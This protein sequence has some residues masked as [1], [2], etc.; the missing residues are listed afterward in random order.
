LTGVCFI[1]DKKKVVITVIGKDTVGIVAKIAVLCAENNVN[2]IDVTQS[3]LGE[4]TFAMIMLVD[5]TSISV[6]FSDFNGKLDVIA[7][8]NNL[9]IH[10]VHE[11]VFNT[12]HHI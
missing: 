5:I 1:L 9:K 6:D 10:S 8:I 11:D 2:I 3:I 7:Q 4:N 12:M